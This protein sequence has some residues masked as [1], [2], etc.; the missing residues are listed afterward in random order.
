MGLST[1]VQTAELADQSNQA[2][3]RHWQPW[4]TLHASGRSECAGLQVHDSCGAVTPG[5]QILPAGRR[6]PLAGRQCAWLG[7]CRRALWAPGEA[8]KASSAPLIDR[9]AG[10]T[11][12]KAPLGGRRGRRKGGWRQV[13]RSHEHCWAC[14]LAGHPLLHVCVHVLPTPAAASA[15]PQGAV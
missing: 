8:S 6:R 13:A 7:T 11:T 10:H 15:R 1:G 5:R 14:P 9:L 3:V 12:K 2:G 4:A